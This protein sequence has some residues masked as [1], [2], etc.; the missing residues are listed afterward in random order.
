MVQR[1]GYGVAA[2][3]ISALISLVFNTRLAGAVKEEAVTLGAPVLEEIIKTGLAALLG[4]DI[5]SSHVAFGAVEA[6]YDA[7]RS[8]SRRSCLAGALA[9]LSHAFFGAAAVMTADRSGNLAAGIFISALLHIG[10][11]GWVMGNRVQSKK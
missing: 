11:N 10:W 5:L 6:F 1:V 9:L 2:G 3:L 4:G 7:A 8:W